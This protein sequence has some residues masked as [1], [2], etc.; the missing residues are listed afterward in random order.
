MLIQAYRYFEGI[1]GNNSKKGELFG[2]ENIFKLHED[3]LATKMTVRR[4]VVLVLF[5]ILSCDFTF[6]AQIEKANLAELD[7]ALANMGSE[8]SRKTTDKS[9]TE[10]ME[11]DTKVNKEDVCI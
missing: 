7:W 2:L 5:H 1:Q 6:L 4:F 9:A 11:A 8:R 3:E 10:T